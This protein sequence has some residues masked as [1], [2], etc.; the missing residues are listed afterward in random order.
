MFVFFF[1]LFCFTWL[2]SIFATYTH[3]AN[4]PVIELDE[5]ALARQTNALGTPVNMFL[6]SRGFSLVSPDGLEIPSGEPFPSGAEGMVA[7]LGMVLLAAMLAMKLL[8]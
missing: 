3:V 5:D 8:Y 6:E 7:A 2:N 4:N 1:V